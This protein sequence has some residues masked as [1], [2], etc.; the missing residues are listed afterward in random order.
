MR[1]KVFVLAFLGIMVFPM[2]SYFIDINI[3]P[4]VMDLYVASQ[5]FSLVHMVLAKVF[6]S[7]SVCAR[8][9]DF[10]VGC[11]LLLQV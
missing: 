1:P 9:H 5:D 2:R 7:L 8:E 3:L 4:V 10:F 11:N 6:R